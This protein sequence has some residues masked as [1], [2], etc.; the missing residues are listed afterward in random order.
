MHAGEQLN[1]NRSVQRKASNDSQG[2]ELAE[3][4]NNSPAMVAQ[5]KQ[6]DGMFG[7][8][9]QRVEEEEPLQGKFETAQRVEEEEQLQGKF[10]TAQRVE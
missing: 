9:I 2:G 5:R 8:A 10:D 6:L 1:R 4:I 7:A 3:Q